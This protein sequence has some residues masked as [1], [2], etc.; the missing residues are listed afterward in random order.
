M[1]HTSCGPCAEI[2]FIPSQVSKALIC[3]LKKLHSLSKNDYGLFSSYLHFQRRQHNCSKCLSWWGPLLRGVPHCSWGHRE[4]GHDVRGLPRGE[5][6]AWG[7]D[8]IFGEEGTM[9]VEVITQRED[10]TWRECS[11]EGQGAPWSK[12]A[13]WWGSSPTHV[14][15]GY[16]TG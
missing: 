14:R 15:R 8:T 2:L 4:G 1:T 13:G 7:E 6:I 11:M 3:I 9:W 5:S 10:I 12:G 16:Y